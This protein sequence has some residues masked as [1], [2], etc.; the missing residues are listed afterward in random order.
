MTTQYLSLIA[1]LGPL[2]FV[3]TSVISWS[4][5][6]TQPKL[7]IQAAKAATVVGIITSLVACVIVYQHVLLESALLSSQLP[8]VSIPSSMV[9]NAV[10]ITLT[11]FSLIVLAQITGFASKSL[12]HT[13]AIHFRNGLYVNVLFDR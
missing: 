11:L 9:L 6:G 2:A 3:I 8:I 10:I 5:K 4:Q 7:V 13:W 12:S 1:L